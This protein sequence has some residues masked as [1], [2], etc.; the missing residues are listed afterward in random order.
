MET[1]LMCKVFQVFFVSGPKV[2]A[3]RWLPIHF[4]AETTKSDPEKEKWNY[5]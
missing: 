1:F 2:D 4:Q 3:Y 5:E